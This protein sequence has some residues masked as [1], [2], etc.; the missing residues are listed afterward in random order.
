M[1]GGRILCAKAIPYGSYRQRY[2]LRIYIFDDK[3]YNARLFFI[4]HNLN[5]TYLNN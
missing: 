2:H 5:K 1:A 4:K 3:W